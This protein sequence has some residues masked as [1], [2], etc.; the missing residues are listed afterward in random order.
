MEPYLLVNIFVR[1]FL[2]LLYPYRAKYVRFFRFDR[3]ALVFFGFSITYLPYI[4]HT[5]IPLFAS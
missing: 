5:H 4:L 1:F 2:L 3:L